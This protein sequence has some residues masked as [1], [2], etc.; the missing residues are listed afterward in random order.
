MTLPLG[1]CRL[2]IDLSSAVEFCHCLQQE[3][4]INRFNIIA[5][6]VLSGTQRIGIITGFY[7]M[8]E[9]FGA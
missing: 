5:V 6:L 9:C 2:E 7:Y 1:T 8:F 4:M 3:K